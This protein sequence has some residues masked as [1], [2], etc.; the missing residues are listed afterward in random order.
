MRDLST[1]RVLLVDDTKTNIDILVQTLK[2]DFKLGVALNGKK[3]IEYAIERAKINDIIV[4]T[5]KG[6]EKSMCFGTTEYPWDE[7]KEIL[8]ALKRKNG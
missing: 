8:E 6:H 1:C 2:D 7:K 4:I 3:A 5:G